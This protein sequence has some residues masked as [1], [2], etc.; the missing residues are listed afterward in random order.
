MVNLFLKECWSSFFV[1]LYLRH[2]QLFFVFFYFN[3]VVGETVDMVEFARLED[4][5]PADCEP[6]T[7]VV[8]KGK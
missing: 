3:Q 7:E 4:E 1:I 6:P 8:L 5:P 2:A